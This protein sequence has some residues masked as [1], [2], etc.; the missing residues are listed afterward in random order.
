MGSRSRGSRGSGSAPIF[1]L[2]ALSSQLPTP[3]LWL[4]LRSQAQ[5]TA[6]SEPAPGSQLPDFRKKSRK[7]AN[8]YLCGRNRSR[9]RSLF[10]SFWLPAPGFCESCEGVVGSRKLEPKTSPALFWEQLR[11][12]L[13]LLDSGLR[14]H[15]RLDAEMICYKIVQRALRN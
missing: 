13:W 6:L 4:R 5:L 15:P 9:L 8:K 7:R 1:R 11:S 12:H 2:S 14:S 3:T 10:F